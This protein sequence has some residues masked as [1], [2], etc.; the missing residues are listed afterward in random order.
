MSEAVAI[1]GVVDIS[2]SAFVAPTA[3]VEDGAHLGRGVKVWHFSQVRKGA[4]IG[5]N[6]IIG[7]GCFIDESVPVGEGSKIQNGSE[8]YAPASLG[9]GVFVGPH[10]V[11]TNDLHPRAVARDGAV[12][13]ATDWHATG[14]RIDEGA[15]LG[16]GSVIVCTSVGAWALVGAGSVVTR[17][18]APHAL[19]VGNPAR[20]IGWVCYCG[21]R[22]EGECETCGWR[23]P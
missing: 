20:Q 2:D 21:E 23:A 17:P 7:K 3:I 12:L 14:C 16:A 9:R 8:I 18:V 6:T 11:L 4:S 1:R 10:V 19:V 15:A 5:D 22:V 13:G